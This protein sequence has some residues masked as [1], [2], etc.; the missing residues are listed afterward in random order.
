MQMKRKVENHLL[1]YILKMNV[2]FKSLDQP[3]LKSLIL[4]F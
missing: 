2:L 1:S 3:E 4:H